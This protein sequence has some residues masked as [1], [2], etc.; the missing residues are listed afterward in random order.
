MSEER[1]TSSKLP[2]GDPPSG[3]EWF[4]AVIKRVEEMHNA[5]VGPGSQVQLLVAR[6]TEM[7]TATEKL[8]AD[9]TQEGGRFSQLEGVLTQIK[10]QAA[11]AQKR[12]DA[13]WETMKHEHELWRERVANVEERQNDLDRRLTTL[14]QKA[15]AE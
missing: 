12:V 5:T 3:Y 4:Y 9:V 13:N 15:A 8:I 7:T 2:P 10:D 14:E 1:T 11:D 6:V